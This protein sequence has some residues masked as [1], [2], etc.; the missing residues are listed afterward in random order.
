MPSTSLSHSEPHSNHRGS[1]S[2][3]RDVDGGRRAKDGRIGPKR[4][5]VGP[6]GVSSG[7][8]TRVSPGLASQGIELPEADSGASAGSAES[9][10]ERLNHNVATYD[11]VPR[12]V[13]GERAHGVNF[14]D[15]GAM[16]DAID[17][18]AVAARLREAV[19]ATGKSMRQI[20]IA[21]GHVPPQLSNQ[22]LAASKGAS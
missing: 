18:P 22:I 16:G 5:E 3:E 8:L 13:N 20:D 2:A 17:W 10:R 14:S 6:P 21:L 7:Y 9:I 1:L 19:E 12:R 11:V 15:N 4:L